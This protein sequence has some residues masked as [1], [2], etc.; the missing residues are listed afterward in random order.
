[1]IAVPEPEPDMAATHTQPNQP[2]PDPLLVFAATVPPTS[3]SALPT[4]LA[5]KRRKSKI[6]GSQTLSILSLLPDPPAPPCAP[7]LI[8]EER[9]PFPENMQQLA[10]F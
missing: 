6:S 5:K 9:E 8:R 7:H 10:L 4:E 3:R 1:M 2:T